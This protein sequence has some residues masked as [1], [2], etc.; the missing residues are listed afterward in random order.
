MTTHCSRSVYGYCAGRVVGPLE[1]SGRQIVDRGQANVPVLLQGAM[2]E[3]PGWLKGQPDYNPIGFP[4][5]GAVNTLE[6]WGVNFLRLTLSA[7]IWDA[8]CD[9]PYRASYPGGYRAEVK[10]TVSTLTSAGIYVVL[11]LYTSNPDCLLDGPT[12]SGTA[13]LPGT[14]AIQFWQQVSAEFANNPLVGFEPWNE[15]EI[16]ATGPQTAKP[17]GTVSACTQAELDAGWSKSLRVTSKTASGQTVSYQDVGM[18]R[19]YQIIHRAAP[20]RL[21][22]LDANGWAAQTATYQHLPAAMRRSSQLVYALHPYDCQ[23]KTKAG[24]EAIAACREETPEDCS[25]ITD[26]IIDSETN[27][28]TGARLSRPVVFD[29]IGFP[30]GEQAYYAPGTINGVANYYP[31][32]LVQ[33]G[34]YLYNFMAVAQSRGDGFAVFS[35]DDS[36]TGD[37]WNG[38]Y[39]LTRQPVEPGDPGPWHPSPDGTALIK[40]DTGAPLTCLDPPDNYDTW[41]PTG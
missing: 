23:D 32:S 39:L 21:V 22:F 24:A 37:T 4:D 6:S 34:L 11:T 17:V 36:D 41:A 3:G 5:K 26:R 25:T 19:L 31:I 18:S 15:P 20:E 29:E 14:D 8:K 2:F 28:S 9:E 1:V 16:C 35:F 40:A 7:D 33:K 10:R 38:P 13:P 27:H 12:V 30:E